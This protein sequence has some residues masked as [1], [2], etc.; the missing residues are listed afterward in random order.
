MNTEK[1]GNT[2]KGC[3]MLAIKKAVALIGGQTETGRRLKVPQQAVSAWVN[4][5]RQAPAKYIQQ[6]SALTNGEVTVDQL[7]ADHANN[8]K[9]ERE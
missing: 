5:S 9:D 2:E 3:I 7:L 6:I 1:T 4:K 8:H